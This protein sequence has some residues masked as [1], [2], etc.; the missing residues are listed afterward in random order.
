MLPHLV[1]QIDQD[2][3][4]R[5]GIRLPDVAVPLA[6]FTGWNFRKASIGATTQ[7]YPLLGSYVPFPATRADRDRT[8]DPRLSIEER[9]PSRERYLMLVQEAATALARD[10]YLLPEDL[11]ALMEHAGEHWDLLVHHAPPRDATAAVR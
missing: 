8:H 4:E 1:P 11:P 10:R 5:A 7:L 3:N 2:G 9:Y 6:T